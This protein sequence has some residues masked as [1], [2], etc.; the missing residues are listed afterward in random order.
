MAKQL[1]IVEE[2]GLTER[3]LRTAPVGQPI[4]PIFFNDVAAVLVR[5]K[6]LS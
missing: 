3:L 1:P 6:L 2:V 5:N 4:P